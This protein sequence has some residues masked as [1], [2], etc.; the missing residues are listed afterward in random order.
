[1]IIQ[2]DFLTHWK[3]QAL[4]GAIGRLEAVTTLLTIWGALSD[5]QGLRSSLHA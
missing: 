3:V 2:P 1:M 5:L 4:S